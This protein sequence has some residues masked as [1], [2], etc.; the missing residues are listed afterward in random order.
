MFG[1]IVIIILAAFAA[2]GI[3]AFVVSKKV[4]DEGVE[5]D[6]EIS[7]VEIHEWSGGTGEWAGSDITKD[8]Y[9]TY[10]NEEAQIVEAL[11]TNPGNHTFKEGDKIR[12]KYLSERQDY[13]VLVE[14]G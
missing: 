13:P 12:I 10:T 8:Y 5:T 4:K 11:L 3:W 1:I 14:A 7:R 2:G 6:A 9:V